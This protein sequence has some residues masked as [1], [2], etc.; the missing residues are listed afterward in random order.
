[1]PSVG[2]ALQCFI[3][4]L[5]VLVWASA[6]SHVHHAGLSDILLDMGVDTQLHVK[7]KVTDPSAVTKLE[8][9][10][11]MT[12]KSKHTISIQLVAAWQLSLPL[13]VAEHGLHIM[14]HI[15]AQV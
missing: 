3:Y 5:T 14:R 7:S 1:M 12:L 8:R 11:T 2:L 4:M 9:K 13:S 15:A 10:L 6:A